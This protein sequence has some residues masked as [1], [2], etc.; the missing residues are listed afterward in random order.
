MK[1][2]EFVGLTGMSLAG[3][4]VPLT[5]NSVPIDVLLESPLSPVEKKQ[6][7]DAALNT[8]KSL[9]A[10][11]TDV[12]I[13]RYL[14]QFV[15]TREKKVQNIINTE[16]FG[17][18]IRVIV[19]GTW[20]FAASN[21]VTTDGLKKTT[22][23]AVAI[24]KANSKFQKEPIKL[25]ATPSYGEVSWKTPIVK[26]GFEVPVKEKVDL[27]L[28]ANAKAL[29]KGANFVNSIIFLVNE[30]KY[31]ASSEGSYIDQ[32][33]H[34]TWPG[35]TVSM[36]DRQSG[37]FKNR[38]AF[39]SPVGM[40][41][42][43]LDGK[44][45]D[46]IASRRRYKTSARNFRRWK[47]AATS[48]P[49]SRAKDNRAKRANRQLQENGA[50]CRRAVLQ[51]QTPTILFQLAINLFRH[52]QMLPHCLG[53]FV[54]ETFHLRIAPVFCLLFERGQIFFM[55]FH[56]RIHIILV[57]LPL[58]RF[59]FRRPLDI[60]FLGDRLQIFIRL[61]VVLHHPSSK[62]FHFAIARVL[63]CHTTHRHFHHSAFGRIFDESLVS[64]TQCAR[65]SL[66]TV[67]IGL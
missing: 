43:Y 64:R 26:N 48:L 32:D 50:P 57:R 61:A 65:F 11:Y 67:A 24:A 23:R 35:F 16:S 18:G 19:N 10:T 62:V 46:K 8:A 5:G 3:M 56:H 17:V 4:M 47:I 28:N 42:E 41:Y 27:L 34:R 31:F 25:A 20:G 59:L 2:R 38:D 51:Q 14:N 52:F 39:S 9:G 15:T 37:Q 53:G 1:R 12:R 33:V 66:V 22:E 58:A 60:F 54:G 63:L 6:L 40:G 7:A 13:G 45:E 21:N 55:I 29:E 30:Q 36:I 49:K 44:A